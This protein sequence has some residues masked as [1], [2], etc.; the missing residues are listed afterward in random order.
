MRRVLPL[1]AALAV[2]APGPAHAGGALRV[3]AAE[4]MW[5]SIAAQLG[6]NRVQVTSIITNPATDPHEYEPSGI[7]ARTL[8][9]AQLV[10]VNG[11]GY[12]TWATQLL[13]ANPVKG[14]VELDVG[15]LVGLHPGD[16]PHQWYSP[17]NVQRVIAAIT[18]DYTTLDPR[19]ASYFAEQKR[20]FE[21]RGL[22]Q[23]KQLIAAIAKRYRGVPV[24]ASESIFAPLADA[25]GLRLLTPSS[26]LKA[27]SEG[28]EP[29]AADTTAIDNQIATHAIKVWVL[30]SQNSTPDVARITAAARKRGIPVATVTETLSPANA[31]FESWQVAELRALAAALHAATAR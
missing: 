4:N 13:A 26:F 6:G 27:I 29:T 2:L 3:V 16:N 30:N 10:V 24:G 31:T 28:T 21:T 15:D 11:I 5:G 14:R 25:L 12:D 1:A 22:A 20:A 23:Y 17:P 18:R 8:A 19:D 7:D 9:Q